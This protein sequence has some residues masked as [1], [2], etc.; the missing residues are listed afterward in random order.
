M[1]VKLRIAK[2]FTNLYCLNKPKP[3]NHHTTP[4]VKKLKPLLLVKFAFE[5]T[6]NKYKKLVSFNYFLVNF[7]LASK[8]L[9]YGS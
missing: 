4:G 7:H 8:K 6:K 3:K 9:V 1:L 2:S 5:I